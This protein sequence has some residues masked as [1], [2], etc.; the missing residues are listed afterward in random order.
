MFPYFFLSIL[1]TLGELQIRGASQSPANGNTGVLE[2]EILQEG[3]EVCRGWWQ[4]AVQMWRASLRGASPRAFLSLL[5]PELRH[6]T[7][8][9]QMA[10][11]LL[12]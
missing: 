12:G 4:E 11:H 3:R 8:G 10:A 1:L 7:S 2:A 6:C 5:L 9:I